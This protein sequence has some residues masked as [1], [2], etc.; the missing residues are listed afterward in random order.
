MKHE[1][2]PT[3]DCEAARRLAVS[4]LYDE[5]DAA[6]RAE[7]D[8]HLAACVPCRDAHRDHR[9]VVRTLDTWR[10]DATTTRAR[11]SGRWLRIAVVAAAS[12]LVLALLGTRVSFR[13]GS[14]IVGFRAFGADTLPS[15][16]A[17]DARLRALASEE[18]S[19]RV[20]ALSAVVESTLGDIVNEQ[21]GRRIALAL[22]VD[23]RLEAERQR[24]EAALR[25][26][27]RMALGESVRMQDELARLAS[28]RP[29]QK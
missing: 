28:T 9:D 25:V 3:Q 17:T 14:F 6:G 11:P 5:L 24:A 10:P 7:L 13:D 27:A 2:L 8:A 12:V 15:A 22:A 1:P 18:A 23:E 21:E 20:R 26:L 4:A 16:R 29:G 19:R